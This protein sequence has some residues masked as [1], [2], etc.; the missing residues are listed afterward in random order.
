MAKPLGQTSFGAIPTGT[1]TKNRFVKRLANTTIGGEEYAAVQRA[2]DKTVAGAEYIVGVS[3][4]DGENGDTRTINIVDGGYIDIEAGGAINPANKAHRKLTTD[5]DG[6]VI[7]WS[8]G[9]HLLATPR[10]TKT[11]AAGQKIRCK[12]LIGID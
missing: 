7:V 5:A 1:V 6:R 12:L 3:E 4:H 8:A 9:D 2:T 10:G 11:V